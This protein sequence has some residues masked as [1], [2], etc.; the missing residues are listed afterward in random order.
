MTNLDEAKSYIDSCYLDRIGKINK[1]KNVFQSSDFENNEE[2]YCDTLIVMLYAQLEGFVTDVLMYYIEEINCKNLK[3]KDVNHNICAASKSDC[4]KNLED[5]IKSKSKYLGRIKFISEYYD[6]WDDKIDLPLYLVNT[7]NNL[8]EK[9]LSELMLKLGFPIDKFGKYSN[10]IDEF[11]NIR[12]G[13]AHGNQNKRIV[14]R[15]EYEKF[16]NLIINEVIIELKDLIFD[17]IRNAL[18]LKN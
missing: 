8:K 18:Y 12:N 5:H 7:K 9:V 13:V 15:R 6:F 16:E 14:T 2:L 17:S 1:L 11:V 4:F 3:Y 10:I